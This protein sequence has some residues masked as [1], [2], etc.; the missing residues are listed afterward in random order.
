MEDYNKK[1]EKFLK[2]TN[3]SFKAEFLKNGLYFPEDEEDKEMRDIYKI[4]LT[5]GELIY[6]FK[7]GQS[8]NKSD[9]KTKPTPYDVLASLTKNNPGDFKEFC[10]SFGYE[11]EDSRKAEK[12]YKAV[13][14]EWKNI[15][16]LFNDEEI[17]RLGEIN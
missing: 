10:D 16:I 8:I 2:D 3:T 9:G 15:E 14:E 11:I 5:R 6:K 1:A 7:F 17:N 12:I 4:T 13:V